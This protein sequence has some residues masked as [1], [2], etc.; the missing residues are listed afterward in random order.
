M[1]TAPLPDLAAVA[2]AGI[3]LFCILALLHVGILWSPHLRSVNAHRNC[4]YK[5]SAM[6]IGR[7]NFRLRFGEA[8]VALKVSPGLLATGVSPIIKYDNPTHG[9]K[10]VQI[11][12]GILVAI[13]KVSIKAKDGY[14]VTTGGQSLPPSRA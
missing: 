7:C 12:K 1:S 8:L 9:D 5:V 6:I 13:I 4:F 10:I 3:S 2:G 14:C 11:V